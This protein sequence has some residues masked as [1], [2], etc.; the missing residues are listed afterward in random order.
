MGMLISFL[1]TLQMLKPMTFGLLYS[2]GNIVSFLSTGFLIGPK[3]QLKSACEAK[4]AAATIIFFVS[5][6]GTI[7]AAVYVKSIILV[8]ILIVIQFSALVWYTA[9][10]IPFAQS[11]ITSTLQAV[12]R[13]GT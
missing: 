3:R 7:T 8:L 1:A 4:R 13:R 11:F 10:Y 2:L 12:C 9:S 5:I 6:V